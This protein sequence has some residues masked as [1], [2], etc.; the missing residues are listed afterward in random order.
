MQV[1]DAEN[2]AGLARP[3]PARVQGRAAPHGEGPAMAIHVAARF[4]TTGR[5]AAGASTAP[6]RRAQQ[7]GTFVGILLGLVLGAGAAAGVA[8]F[9][10]QSP[11]PFTTQAADRGKAIQPAPAVPSPVPTVAPAAGQLPDPNQGASRQQVMPQPDPRNVVQSQG[12]STVDVTEAEQAASVGEPAATVAEVDAAQATAQAQSGNTGYLL[13][14][15]S[16]RRR[17][18]AEGLKG[19]L[20]LRGLEARVESGS[21][22]G[23]TVYRVRIGPYHSLD[24]VNRVR[25]GLADNGIEAAVVRAR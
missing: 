9:I 25:R 13:Q 12:V 8:W 11:L 16:F 1:L 3:L 24:Q 20:A 10:Y 22:N 6:G 2:H 23:Q 14:A 5:G 4:H 15:G 7:G 18:D 19:D 21:V 17:N